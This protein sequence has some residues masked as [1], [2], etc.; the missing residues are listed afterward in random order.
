MP[1]N[2]PQ[3][4]QQLRAKSG[5]ASQRQAEFQRRRQQA[6]ELLHAQAGELE[7]LRQ[8][9]EQAAAQER[10]LRCA[11]PLDEHLDSA[12]PAPQVN[13][14][15]LLLA[16]DGSQIN[17]NRHDPVEFAVIN[18]GLI[19][20]APG[21]G[22]APQEHT[23]S[24]LFIFEDLDGSQ[25]PL[26]EELVALTRDLNERRELAERAAQ[27]HGPRP[28]LTLTD[29][30]LEL[31][32]EPKDDARFEQRFKDYLAVLERLAQMSVVTAGYVDK[33]RAD[34]VVR[35]LELG[36]YT[37][38]EMQRAGKERPLAG[39]KDSDLYKDMIKPGERTPLFAIQ[40][41]SNER[42]RERM[43]GALGVC[44]FYLNVG[45]EGSPWLARVE[46]PAWVSQR[47]ESVDLLH[48][49]L[50]QQARQ[51][52]SRAYPYA[53]HRA[54]EIALVTFQEKQQIQ[55]LI[56]NELRRLGIEPGQQSYKQ[57]SK[58]LQGRRSY[59]R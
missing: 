17:P 54:H 58:D 13:D 18:I 45:R 32:R 33:P 30:P 57:A 10:S 26:T 14:Y 8:R 53:L 5:T 20:I 28:V 39:V 46:L 29:G 2:Y 41:P 42:F 47:K 36:L 19:R 23:A 50:L 34:L 27:E 31:Y 35:L 9:V 11:L 1:V 38:E 15:P 51:M 59:R 7:V 25:G 52:G 37:A 43:G 55:L 16:A 48:A 6:L 22:H 12:C 3:I 24:Q 44:F 56:E 40:S 4:Q 21:E 49:T